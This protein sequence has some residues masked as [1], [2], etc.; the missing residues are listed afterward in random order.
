MRV[1]TVR[2]ALSHCHCDYNMLDK[3]ILPENDECSQ[4]DLQM[5]NAPKVAT[6]AMG[7][8]A[9]DAQAL[10]ILCSDNIHTGG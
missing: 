5:M 6:I 1:S 3:L 8:R 9:C 7:D 2:S 10:K 4:G